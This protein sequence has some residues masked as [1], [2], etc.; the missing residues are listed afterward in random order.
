VG[1]KAKKPDPQQVQQIKAQHANFRAQ[2]KPQ[3][4]P[5]LPS[6]KTIGLKEAITGRVS[7]M[8][9]SFVSSGTA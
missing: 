3:Q 8:K 7:N 1:A 6:T 9:Y 2:P 5:R 4:V